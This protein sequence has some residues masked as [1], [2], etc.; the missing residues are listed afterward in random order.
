MLN[1]YLGRQPIFDVRMDVMGY[2]ILFRPHEDALVSGAGVL[3]GDMATSRVILDSLFEAGL[4]KLVGG[5]PAFINLTRGFVVNP[6]LLPPPSPQLV[7]EVLEDIEVDDEV[8]AGV[9]ALK[10]RGY[11]VALDDFIY[12]EKWVPLL[13]LADIV[14]VDLR[15]ADRAQVTAC[16]K[17]LSKY[18]LKL[19]AEKIEDEAEFIWC[20][21]AGFDY[22]QGYFLCQPQMKKGK[23]LPTNRLHILR[24][25][26]RLQDDAVQ[27]SELER[28]ISEDVTLSFKLLKYINSP[29]FGTRSKITSIKHAV[30]YLGMKEVRR[31]GNLV[32]LLGVDDNPEELMVIG[33][34][35]AKMCELLA[36]ARGNF[37]QG[38][39]FLIG[40]FSILDAIMGAPLDE[41][42]ENLPLSSDVTDALLNNSGGYSKFL[43]VAKAHEQGSWHETDLDSDL[44]GIPL[45]DLYL[46]SLGWASMTR[47]SLRQ[48]SA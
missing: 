33:L 21:D 22:F 25:L 36:S 3:N 24:I 10:Q 9:R 30:V 19:L 39:A 20:K 40:L 15:A 35:R 32:A 13:E 42:L 4:D 38:M 11:T 44:A 17:Q 14:K 45:A 37:D 18:P 41:I 8:I 46:Q 43:Q 48:G 26:A 34:V 47:D 1:Y 2:E 6:D 29:A 31:W 16:L 7:L 5:H 12:D 23:R 28:I 27:V